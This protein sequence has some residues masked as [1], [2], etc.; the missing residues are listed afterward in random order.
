[1]NYLNPL[2]FSVNIFDNKD[3]KVFVKNVDIKDGMVYANG[4]IVVPK[5]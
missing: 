2:D 3:A 4:I 5:D 1:M